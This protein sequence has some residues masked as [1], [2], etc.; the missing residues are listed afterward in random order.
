MFWGA[1]F[2]LSQS[3]VGVPL[4]IPPLPVPSG[5][6]ALL[7]VPKELHREQQGKKRLD[8]EWV[9]H[10]LCSTITRLLISDGDGR[11]TR[12]LRIVDPGKEERLV[13]CCFL[14]FRW[15]DVVLWWWRASGRVRLVLVC[16]CAKRPGDE[17]TGVRLELKSSSR[18][19]KLSSDPSEPPVPMLHTSHNALRQ[20]SYFK[21]RV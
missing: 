6:R 1:W 17:V 20:T 4:R 13:L 14:G 16:V 2:F 10:S 11:V 18:P 3:D 9:G 19:L 8:D 7:S 21:M 15:W 5:G 12:S